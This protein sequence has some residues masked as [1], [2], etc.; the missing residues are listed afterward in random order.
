MVA[1]DAI[2][3]LGLVLRSS[4]SAAARQQTALLASRLGYG[5]VWLPV[6]ANEDSS[7]VEATL[8]ELGHL[9][10][11]AAPARVGVMLDGDSDDVAS[12]LRAADFGRR[13]FLAQLAAP[14]TSRP[15]LVSA[16]G[17]TSAWRSRVQTGGFYET[18][19]AGLVIAASSRGETVRAVQEAVEARRQV[20]ANVQQLPIIVSLAVS[21]GRT[22][23][24]AEARAAR[25]PILAGS[26]HPRQSGLFGTFEDAQNQALA[27]AAAG[28][29]EL[30]VTLADEHDVADLLAQ[31]RAV[32]VGPTPVLHAGRRSSASDGE[33]G[34]DPLSRL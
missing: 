12:W 28:A 2:L 15:A 9:A 27:L 34:V 7:A 1:P 29:D 25:D 11:A 21:I 6:T 26:A 20:S 3:R 13:E 24:E 5:S 10:T 4:H 23:S 17:G 16:A 19:A 33:V 14:A 22:M 8:A 31:L 32:V 30:R 18:A